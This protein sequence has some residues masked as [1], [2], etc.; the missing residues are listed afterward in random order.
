MIRA[1]SRDAQEC[2]K[3][4]PAATVRYAQTSFELLHPP[5]SLFPS[6]NRTTVRMALRSTVF[7]ARL[8]VADLDRGHHETHAL[9]VAR[10]PSETDERLMVRVLVFALFASEGLA[11]GR[12]LSDADEPDLVERDLTGAITRWI[13]VGLPDDRAILKACGKAGSVVVAAYGTGVGLWWKGVAGK[14]ARARNLEVWTVSTEISR[15]LAAMATRSMDLQ[16]TIQEGLVWFS[17]GAETVE[18]QPERLFPAP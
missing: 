4:P 7:K 15:A 6:P 14:V 5:L 16:A 9:I 2:L 12:G 3:I 10:H 13:E 11:F 8:A 1:G 17:D 18:L